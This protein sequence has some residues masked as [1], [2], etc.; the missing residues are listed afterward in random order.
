MSPTPSPSSLSH[1]WIW[2]WG[3][4]P[5]VSTAVEKNQKDEGRGKKKTLHLHLNISC[6][7]APIWGL[8]WVEEM[9][10]Y[11][12]MHG[13]MVENEL[14]ATFSFQW[15]LKTKIYAMFVNSSKTHIKP[16]VWVSQS[17][18]ECLQH[19]DACYNKAGRVILMM[20]FRSQLGP[21]R[22]SKCSCTTAL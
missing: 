16:K 3:K 19:N 20:P 4:E 12:M 13:F 1:F 8:F 9:H 18:K 15:W 5:L 22:E 6:I 17:V 11:F 2:V 14:C 7:K 10:K 21:L